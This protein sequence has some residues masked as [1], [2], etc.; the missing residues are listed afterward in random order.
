MASNKHGRCKRGIRPRVGSIERPNVAR[1]ETVV[2]FWQYIALG[3]TS[4]QAGIHVGV[5]QAAGARWFRQ[6]DGMPNLELDPPSDRYLTFAE[7]EQ[8]VLF[9]V[10]GHGV[11]EIAS[12][13]MRSPSTVSRELKRNAATRGAYVDYRA[14]TARWHADRR[15]NR[16]ALAA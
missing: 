7:R 13:L 11:R 2:L 8:I 5:S 4:E 10:E 6:G 1:R 16:P 9:C 3:H 12:R 14:T 15:A